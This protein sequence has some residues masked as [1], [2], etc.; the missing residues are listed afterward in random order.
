MSICCV[1]FCIG[2]R[3]CGAVLW[4]LL[5]LVVGRGQHVEIVCSREVFVIGADL[6][7]VAGWRGHH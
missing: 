5:D 2:V 7:W 4:P 6:S 3:V 1:W